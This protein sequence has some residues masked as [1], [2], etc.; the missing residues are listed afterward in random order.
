MK[1]TIRKNRIYIEI[2]SKCYNGIIHSKTYVTWDEWPP[3]YARIEAK[4]KLSKIVN[5][6]DR[7]E[8]QPNGLYDRIW[9]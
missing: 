9:V 4:L 7:V 6:V 3:E 8:Y 5:I 1:I 2:G